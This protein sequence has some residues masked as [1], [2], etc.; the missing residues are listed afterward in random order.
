MY[1]LL[2]PSGYIITMFTT[3]HPFLV[4][5]NV[6]QRNPKW[7]QYAKI[8]KTWDVFYTKGKDPKSEY[9]KVLKETGF[10]IIDCQTVQRS[11]THTSMKAFIDYFESINPFKKRIPAERA[12][13]FL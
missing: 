12:Q 3:S 6:L 13:E 4:L 10:E 8:W 11:F 9:I 5:F 7:Q 1:A 2:K